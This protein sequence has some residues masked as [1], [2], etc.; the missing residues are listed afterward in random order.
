MHQDA[1]CY[2]KQSLINAP[3]L[4][5]SDFTQ[6][7]VLET[8]ASGM[9]LG[10]IL[11]QVHEDGTSYPIAYASRT[12]QQHERK[13]VATELEALGTVWAVKHFHHYLYGHHCEV[14]TDHEPLGFVKNSSFIRKSSQ[15]EFNFTGIGSCHS[16]LPMSGRVILM[17]VLIPYP[18]FLWTR[19]AVVPIFL[20]ILPK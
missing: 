19:M 2:L 3:D 20:T 10:V 16:I 4:E 1:F 14:Y 5:F 6:D 11:A 7:F 17:L 9:G 13:Y 12:L 18:V 8:D 15:V